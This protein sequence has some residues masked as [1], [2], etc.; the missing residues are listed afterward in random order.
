V[1]KKISIA[2]VTYNNENIIR[3]TVESIVSHIENLFNYAL[4]VIDNNSTD[5]TVKEV[6][7][8]RGN[9]TLLQNKKN[10][11][12][13]AAHN[14]V[15]EMLDSEYHLVVNPDI[16]IVNDAISDMYTYMEEH[17]DI[18]L[19]TPLVKHPDGRIQY[20]CKRNPTI[21]DLFIRLALPNYF[22]KRQDYFTMKETGYDKPFL[23][24]YATG[25]FMFFRTDI[26][27]RLNG[28]DEH[29]FLYLEDADITRRVNQISKTIFYPYNYV[30]HDWQRE[31][32]KKLKLMWINVKSAAWYF[33][34]W[35]L[36]KKH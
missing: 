16:T 7:S 24:E 14:T 20:L 25:C 30:V 35:G 34:K 4:Y 22:K 27:K 1:K 13:G 17:T 8:C 23:V 3:R 11:G 6:L 2:I 31:Q 19:L 33:L 18:G 29:I 9:I 32:H 21:T 28:F 5:N 26:F 10:I 15:I 12:F 36:R